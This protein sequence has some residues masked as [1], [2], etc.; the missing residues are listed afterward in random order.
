MGIQSQCGVGRAAK[1]DIIGKTG[2][3]CAAES[4]ARQFTRLCHLFSLFVF[5]VFPPKNRS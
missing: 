3:D 2:G 5:V 1:T 4:A